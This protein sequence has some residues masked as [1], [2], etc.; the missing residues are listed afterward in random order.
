MKLIVGLGNPGEKYL[1][2]P[3]NIGWIVI[4]ALAQSWSAE[5]CSKKK[6]SAQTTVVELENRQKIFLIKPLTY[7]NLSGL[8]VQKAMHYYRLSLNDLLVIHDDIDL[9]FL[10][11]RFQ[12][13]R[14]PAGHN[15]LRSINKE[16]GSQDYTRLRVGMSTIQTNMSSGSSAK[17]KQTGWWPVLSSFYIEG[18]SFPM[19]NPMDRLVPQP[20]SKKLIKDKEREFNKTKKEEVKEIEQNK[21]DTK[22]ESV[23]REVLKPFTKT[24]QNLLP[25]FLNTTIKAIQYFIKEGLE[26][27][28]NQ[29]NKPVSVP[30]D[31]A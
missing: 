19:K 12:K 16:L 7:M 23:K 4:D 11:L 27:T 2:T 1:L 29:Y 21:E 14:G 30:V 13:N 3:H 22:R 20:S 15:G 28:A 25:D 8:A 17:K 10:S 6:F 9:S 5:W 31:Q 18:L 26:K 24:E